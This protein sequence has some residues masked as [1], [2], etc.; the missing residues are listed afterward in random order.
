MMNLLGRR[1]NECNSGLSRLVLVCVFVGVG[2]GLLLPGSASAFVL[3][4]VQLD[5]GVCGQNLQ[6]GS[7]PTASASAT[8]SFLLSGDGGLSS[9]AISIDGVSIGTFK[10]DGFGNVCIR[11]T[12]ALA[13]GAHQLTG[14]ELAP[15]AGN[16]V[17]PFAFS[18]DTVAPPAPSAVA[19]NWSSDTGVAGGETPQPP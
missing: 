11:T 3:N 5:N 1:R 14:T 7:D 15:H 4:Q 9:Y 16:V 19:L 12:V 13:D 6:V 10:S 18:V 2:V 17:G 8:P